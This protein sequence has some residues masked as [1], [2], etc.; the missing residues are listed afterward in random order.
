MYWVLYWQT[1]WVY[2]KNKQHKWN[3]FFLNCAARKDTLKIL[4]S[5]LERKSRSSPDVFSHENFHDASWWR[6]RYL[7]FDS[8]WWLPHSS[9]KTRLRKDLRHGYSVS[10]RQKCWAKSHRHCRYFFISICLVR[11]SIYLMKAVICIMG[12][13]NDTCA[14]VKSLLQRSAK[15]TKYWH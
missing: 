11:S 10:W 4:V 15:G 9:I 12:N 14:A 13:S 7:L 5:T 2:I 3:T 8:H 6:A 1:W